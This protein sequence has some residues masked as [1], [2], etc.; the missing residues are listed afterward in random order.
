MSAPS[1]RKATMDA[2]GI[3]ATAKLVNGNDPFQNS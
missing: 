3:P 1:L 2:R